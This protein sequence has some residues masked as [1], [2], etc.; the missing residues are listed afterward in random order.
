M[1]RKGY[2]SPTGRHFTPVWDQGSRER[3][4]VAGSGLWAR[5]RDAAMQEPGARGPKPGRSR[6]TE[7]PNWSKA[8]RGVAPESGRLALFPTR[9]A[10][11][12]IVL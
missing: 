5:L 11:D 4:E 3:E 12:T 1:F 6:S 10:I 8:E 7:P 9:V 2:A